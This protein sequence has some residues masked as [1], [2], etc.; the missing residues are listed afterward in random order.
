MT[1]PIPSETVDPSKILE[2]AEFIETSDMLHTFIEQH[3]TVFQRYEQ[4]AGVYNQRLQAADKAVRAKGVSCGPFIR[5]SQQIKINWKGFHDWCEGDKERFMDGG[6]SVKK[7]AQYSGE[8]KTMEIRIATGEIPEE[9]AAAFRV[10][11]PRYK[12]PDPVTTV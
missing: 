3:A 11:S 5:F 2:V 10:I 7:V 8:A 6:G 9:E 12:K 4:I 1:K